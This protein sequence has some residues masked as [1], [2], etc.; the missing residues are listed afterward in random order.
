M[1]TRPE[2]INGNNTGILT[3]RSAPLKKLNAALKAGFLRHLDD[4]TIK[5]THLF[6][7][8]YENIYLDESHIPELKTLLAEACTHAG[9]ILQQDKLHAGCWFNYMP[10]GSITLPHRHDD[11]DELL[12]AAYYVD[13]PANSGDLIIHAREG[14]ITIAPEAGMFVFFRPDVSHEVTE[15]KSRLDRLSIGINFGIKT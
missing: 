7:G 14:D 13:V 6:Q 3:V 1:K 15:N 9:Y 5:R 12:S 10:P 8:R 2:P 4:P 11:D